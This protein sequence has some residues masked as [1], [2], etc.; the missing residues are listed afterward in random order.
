MVNY[1]KKVGNEL[2]PGGLNSDTINRDK[3]FR[4]MNMRNMILV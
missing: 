2:K 1:I 4:K 3:D